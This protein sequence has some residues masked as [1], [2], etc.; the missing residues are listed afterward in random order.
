MQQPPFPGQPGGPPVMYGAP[1]MMPGA[2]PMQMGPPM[3]F[4]RPPHFGGGLSKLWM[5]R[6]ELLPGFVHLLTEEHHLAGPPMGMM[7]PPGFPRPQIMMQP[8]A[9]PR[10]MGMMQPQQIPA[11]GAVGMLKKPGPLTTAGFCGAR[12]RMLAR[13]AV[14]WWHNAAAWTAAS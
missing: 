14:L 13:S 5:R 8:P 11:P 6:S 9:F 10:P 1:Q 3:G 12:S 4:P 2:P 7:Q